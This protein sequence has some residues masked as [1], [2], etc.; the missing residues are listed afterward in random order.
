MLNSDGR[1]LFEC[2]IRLIMR[3]HPEYKELISKAR[4]DPT[5]RNIIQI[6][7]LYMEESEVYELLCTDYL[8]NV[9]LCDKSYL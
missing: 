3:E 8:N 1:K 9:M 6:A 2:I 4:K 5:L 7:A